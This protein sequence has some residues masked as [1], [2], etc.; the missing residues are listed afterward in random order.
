LSLS[1]EEASLLDAWVYEV[2]REVRVL[3]LTYGCFTEDLGK[4]SHPTEHWA[5]EA[6]PPR[7][8]GKHQLYRAGTKNRSWIGLITLYSGK[9]QNSDVP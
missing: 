5:V 3:A 7:R 6:L 9:D 1:V 4:I 2:I 8:V